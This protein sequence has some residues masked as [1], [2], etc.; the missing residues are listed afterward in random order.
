M[1]EHVVHDGMHAR[2]LLGVRNEHLEPLSF[3]PF[4]VERILHREG[5]AEESDFADAVGEDGSGRR[6]G[7]M[8]EGDTDHVFDSAGDELHGVSAKHDQV[9]VRALETAGMVG[10][11]RVRGIPLTP[12]LDTLELGKV[13]RVEDDARLVLAAELFPHAFVREAVPLELGFQA[14]PA[15]DA[16]RPHRGA[17]VSS[18]AGGVSGRG[19]D[20][21]HR[22]HLRSGLIGG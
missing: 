14:H 8:E 4:A 5:H 12:G 18:R 11:Q 13:E 15:E 9:C 7:N 16:Y 19:V 20:A 3:E 22:I 1:H 10:E 2:P 21:M 6:V 17:S